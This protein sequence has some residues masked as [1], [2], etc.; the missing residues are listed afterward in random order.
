MLGEIVTV[1]TIVS[2][3]VSEFVAKTSEWAD[4]GRKRAKTQES[5]SGT[6]DNL[7]S[8]FRLELERIAYVGL[9]ENDL[10]FCDW[11]RAKTRYIYDS[12][13]QTKQERDSRIQAL[14]IECLDKFDLEDDGDKAESIKQV[15]NIAFDYCL[16][17]RY[18][19]LNDDDKTVVN[20]A[21]AYGEET[22]SRRNDEMIE[23]LSSE[24][25]E[26]GY[27]QKYQNYLASRATP[28]IGTEFTVDQLYVPLNAI[29]LPKPKED[30]DDDDDDSVYV[31]RPR[32]V[33]ADQFIEEW[34]SQNH[35]NGEPISRVLIISGDPGSGKSTI[36]KRFTKKLAKSGL[37]NVIY[38]R[39]NDLET[40]PSITTIQDL[41]VE[42]I[43]NLQEADLRVSRI[44][45]DKSVVMILDG[46]DEFAASGQKSEQNAWSLLKSV[47]NY[48]RQS[49][50]GSLN[51]RVLVTARNS[52]LRPI[53]AKVDLAAYK[54]I[55]LELLPYYLE[56][57][58][59][60]NRILD[61]DR[62]LE[63]DKRITWWEN[64]GKLLGVDLEPTM[65]KV[66]K[67]DEK[68]K[69]TAQPIL[70]H[71]V[72]INADSIVNKSSANRAEIYDALLR[73]VIKREYESLVGQN[74]PH[75][76]TTIPEINE[77]LYF[78]ELAAINAWH[79]E[80]SVTGL[81]SLKK[82]CERKHA[83]K[84]FLHFKKESQVRGNI[85]AGYFR[86]GPNKS[87]ESY[88]F[89]HYS[90]MEYLVSKHIVSTLISMI[91]RG[92]SPKKCAGR[93]YDLF[94]SDELTENTLSF[95]KAEL[96]LIRI[97]EVNKLRLFSISLFEDFLSDE[98]IVKILSSKSRK[99]K[100]FTTQLRSVH[101]VRMGILSIHS[102]T[103]KITKLKD[104][105][106]YPALNAFLNHSGCFS[107]DAVIQ[108]FLNG[109]IPKR[110]ESG[111]IPVY[112]EYR[113][114]LLRAKRSLILALPYATLVKADLSRSDLSGSIF[115]GSDLSYADL[116]Q[117]KLDNA[118]LQG[119]IM[120]WSECTNASFVNACLVDAYLG[121]ARL[122]HSQFRK[123]QLQRA[124]LID[125]DFRGARLIGAHLDSANLTRADFTGAFL[126][127]AVL[128]EANL[129]GTILRDAILKNA[130]LRSAVFNGA[131]LTGADLTGAMVL[132]KD[133]ALLETLGANLA[134]SLLC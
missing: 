30:D 58:R 125:A 55:R 46:L 110:T 86:S 82:L 69:L 13:L 88:E 71:L 89:V 66:L 18:E 62:L 53:E 47:L 9:D 32:A 84:A 116:T 95:I 4:Q 98:S 76:R 52:M 87:E 133:A 16:K 21:T 70:N 65:K 22:A 10:S 59:D 94:A 79:H 129:T 96:E 74:I 11:L 77:Y 113:V 1:S 118:V 106:N 39:L 114:D 91:K 3:F 64:Y 103:A 63:Q 27:W 126:H 85:I 40:D 41:V 67:W 42:H 101:N 119:A 128:A 122:A 49:E 120:S 93:V 24:G 2:A 35:R 43:R 107:H 34:L 75:G 23:A 81:D 56:K 5:F 44:P 111:S 54:P 115:F 50:E 38:V 28:A 14:L 48:G 20:M 15:I 36:A 109:L 68:E 29:E 51:N 83:E 97:R 131:V 123:A 31:P 37:F 45:R 19:Q 78:M 132:R 134:L 72:A 90:F 17:L 25:I 99:S 112:G 108:R 60:T 80:G 92:A 7:E 57:R 26:R 12:A 100:P 105:I 61:P 102:V 124:T 33:Q 104:P 73:S 117:A 6:L 121:N 127:N 8:E 130:D